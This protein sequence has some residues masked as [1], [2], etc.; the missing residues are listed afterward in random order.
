MSEYQLPIVVPD[1]IPLVDL[2]IMNQ[3]HREEVDLINRLGGLLLEGL[4]QISAYEAI[5]LCL[6]EWI[7][8]TREHFERE[9]RL[10]AE[11]GFPPYPVHKGE[12][13]QVLALIQ[14]LYEQWLKQR[15]LDELVKFVFVE[16]RSWFD[17]HVKSM[18]SVT[19]QFLARIID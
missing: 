1:Q 14:G 6:E 8:H 18:D 10:M 5:D 11:H 7:V 16:W 2:E 13:D 4:Q 19:A 9:N 12:H 3:V 15:D 17:G